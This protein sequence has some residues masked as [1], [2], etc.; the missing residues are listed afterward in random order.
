[1][2]TLAHRRA[3]EF[4]DVYTDALNSGDLPA[5]ASCYAYPSMVVTDTGSVVVASPEDI[6]AAFAAEGQEH[7]ELTS[8]AELRSL[9][10]PT[11]NLAW[12]TVRWSYRDSGGGEV[13]ADSYRYLLRDTAGA[14]RICTI[15]PVPREWSH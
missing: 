2:P 11:Q 1:M 12:I 9:E 8:V 14:V 7:A 13:S 10:S 3:E 15:T 5:I 6:M 4:L